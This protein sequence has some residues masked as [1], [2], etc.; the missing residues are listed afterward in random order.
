M[1]RKMVAATLRT[2]NKAKIVGARTFGDPIVQLFTLL[3]DGNGI[4]MSAARLLDAQGA[5]WNDGFAPDVAAT[6]ADA[7]KRA[8]EALGA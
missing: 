3:K 1:W 4:E 2:A 7:M 8:L 5:E 6:N